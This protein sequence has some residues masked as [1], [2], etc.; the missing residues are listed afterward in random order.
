MEWADWAGFFYEESRRFPGIP[1]WQEQMTGGD[2]HQCFVKADELTEVEVERAIRAF[3]Q[4]N[5]WPA[6][7]PLAAALLRER[8]LAASDLARQL[9][10]LQASLGLGRPP[11]WPRPRLVRWFLLAAWNH[12]CFGQIAGN[13]EQ[14]RPP[15]TKP[16]T[17]RLTPDTEGH[18]SGAM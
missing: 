10:Y 16:D 12:V 14:A 1:D 8:L 3:A 5:V 2:W 11:E 6:R 4:R 18:Q 15:H 9:Q 7:S 13:L 17:P